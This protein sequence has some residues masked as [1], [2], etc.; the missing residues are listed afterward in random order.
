MPF[1]SPPAQKPLPEPV[2]TTHFT[3][4]SSSAQASC[5]PSA[6]FIAS[7]MALRASGRLSVKVSTPPSKVESRSGV[8]V[9]G[10]SVI[11]FPARAIVGWDRWGCSLLPVGNRQSYTCQVRHHGAD[12]LPDGRTFCH[13]SP[14]CQKIRMR[15]GH[16]HGVPR[17]KELCHVE[18]NVSVSQHAR[19]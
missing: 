9:S 19:K 13:A 12:H 8:P 7:L 15:R 1:T 14:P 3:V 4:G 16:G 17:G 2:R 5:S 10:P 6:L 11:T 18:R